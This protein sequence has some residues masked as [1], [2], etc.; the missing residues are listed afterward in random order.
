MQTGPEDDAH[1][2][3]IT[4]SAIIDDDIDTFKEGD[5]I[6]LRMARR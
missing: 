3:E 4:F 2:Y 1:E 5:I 6:L